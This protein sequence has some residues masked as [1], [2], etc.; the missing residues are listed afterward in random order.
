MTMEWC[1]IEKAIH[2]A[3]MII[4]WCFAVLAVI[5]TGGLILGVVLS[6]L[7]YLPPPNQ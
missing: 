5:G 2:F 3:Y 4:V 7:G 1:D 6:G